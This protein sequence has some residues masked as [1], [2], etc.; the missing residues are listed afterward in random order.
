VKLFTSRSETHA[1]ARA[2][3]LAL[4]CAWPLACGHATPFPGKPVTIIVPY[5]AGGSSDVLARVL[6][7]R[8]AEQWGQDVLVDNRP[9]NDSVAGTQAAARAPADGH[10]LL[11]VNAALAINEALSRRLP[12]HALRDFVPISLIARQPVVLVT[13]AESSFASVA[14]LR[15]AAQERPGHLTY[16]SIGHG[17]VGHLAGELFKRAAGVSLAHVTYPGMRQGL[18][19]L[20]AGRIT[21]A[22]VPL[23]VAM[24]HVRNGALRLVAIANSRRAEAFSEVPTIAETFPGFEI[25]NWIGLLAPYGVSVRRVRSIHA[26]VTMIVG[27]HEFRMLMASLGYEAV[28]STPGQFHDRLAADI[29]RYSRAIHT[30]GIRAP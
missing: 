10:T 21:V 29:E 30:V 9:G 1:F 3:C 13:H 27:A 28:G 15:D 2:A 25:D 6:S 7:Q 19:E 22:F 24:P 18:K 23:P 4:L 14:Q 11:A 8:L 26:T 12:Y 5:P 17:S 20:K 16:G